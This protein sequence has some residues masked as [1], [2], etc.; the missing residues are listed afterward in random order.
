MV[1]VEVVQ[2]IHWLMKPPRLMPLQSYN[3]K[4]V[5]HYNVDNSAGGGSTEH[6]D[7]WQVRIAYIYGH[8]HH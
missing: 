1:V 3:A 5:S 7:G 8:I 6:I 4:Y 2:S